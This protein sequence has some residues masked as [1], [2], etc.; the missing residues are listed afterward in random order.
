MTTAHSGCEGTKR[1]SLE[2]VLKAIEL[3]VDAVEIDVRKSPDGTLRIS[4][5]KKPD[6]RA[7]EN[8]ARLEEVFEILKPTTLRVN[9][10]MK[11]RE[12]VYDLLGVADAYDFDR[13]RLIVTGSISPEQLAYDPELLDRMTL[14]M[15]IEELFKYVYLYSGSSNFEEFRKLMTEPWTFTRAFLLNLEGYLPK[16]IDLTGKLGVTK[17]NFPYQ[18][19]R[20]E[21]C[22]ML[23]QAGLGV[24]VW[25]VDDSE[26]MQ[27]FLDFS[28][29]NLENVTTRQVS[30]F[31]RLL[32]QRMAQ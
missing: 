17:L 28:I 10:D 32:K 2:S 21:H 22:R 4:H 19:V 29:G 13:D 25:T 11:E 26:A 12:H 1:D 27:R 3:D 30:T 8:V 31:K 9:C 14:Y 18:Q 16:V 15:N 23:A 20:E 6:V 7:Y 5:D 24:S